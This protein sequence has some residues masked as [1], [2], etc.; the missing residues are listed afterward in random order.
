MWPLRVRPYVTRSVGED[1]PPVR[2]AD[3]G[4]GRVIH[5]PLDVSNGLLGCAEWGVMGYEPSTA[6][7]LMKNVLLWGSAR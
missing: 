5:L 6:Q 2:V 3:V 4:G 1:V 7:A